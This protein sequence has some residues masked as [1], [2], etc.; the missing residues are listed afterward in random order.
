MYYEYYENG[1]VYQSA[2]I[3]NGI[4]NGKR[5]WYY[6]SGRIKQTG[7]YID[8]KCE[9]N[10]INYYEDG[11]IKSITHY[12]NGTALGLK[13]FKFET[14]NQSKTFNSFN[15]S[16]NKNL[17]NKKTDVKNIKSSA[18]KKSTAKVFAGIILLIGII[19]S[20]IY[21]KISDKIDNKQMQPAK[22]TVKTVKKAEK[23]VTNTL[24][25]KITDNK[26]LLQE[27][28]ENKKTKTVVTDNMKK[29]NFIK[30]SQI[31]KKP[32]YKNYILNIG[33]G[34][35]I[36][37]PNEVYINV[38]QDKKNKSL[39]FSSKYN[40]MSIILKRVPLKKV[41]FKELYRQEINSLNGKMTILNADLSRS[42]YYINGKKNKTGIYKYAYYNK[43]EFEVIFI[44]FYY[45][46]SMEKE[47]KK[48]I[49]TTLNNFKKK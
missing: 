34:Y 11:K 37:L 31:L 25:E 1:Q 19:L 10:F 18:N 40:E 33:A 29:D 48:V 35:K 7:N 42:K 27:N 8:G 36:S 24:T 5:V 6:L 43:N 14:S 21:F 23:T 13:E 32:K 16:K 12:H 2:E 4:L 46:L 44:D 45:P 20:I 41:S 47:M 3:Y 49:K 28:I 15:E 22:E 30:L 9:G 38:T 17:N 26:K 39:K